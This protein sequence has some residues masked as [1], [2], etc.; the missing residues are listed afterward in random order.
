MFFI[1]FH[2]HNCVHFIWWIIRHLTLVE[3][4]ILW[5]QMFGGYHRYANLN[6]IMTQDCLGNTFHWKSM[7]E[8]LTHS[9]TYTNL[10]LI[11]P[12]QFIAFLKSIEMNWS[13][14]NNNQK[15]KNKCEQQSKNVTHEHYQS[16]MDEKWLRFSFMLK[17]LNNFHMKDKTSWKNDIIYKKCILINKCSLRHWVMNPLMYKSNKNCIL[18][19]L[20]IYYGTGTR[21]T[22][23]EAR[24]ASCHS[25][26][27][28]VFTK[29]CSRLQLFSFMVDSHL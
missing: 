28:I 17:I 26:R 9:P 21:F 5:V 24:R 19:F 7:F 23:G 18:C 4:E 1:F 25:V 12:M 6:Q 14:T 10:S 22:Y 15:H 27:V 13:M 3:N 20:F 8:D 11:L 29:T 16:K 2:H